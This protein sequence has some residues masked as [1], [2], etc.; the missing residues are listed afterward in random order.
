MEVMELT[1]LTNMHRIA[2]TVL[3]FS[4]VILPLAVSAQ[5]DPMHLR[6]NVVLV[7]L[8]VAVTDD[9]GNYVT[10][11]RPEDFSIT[12]DTR[13]QNPWTIFLKPIRTRNQ[14][15]IPLFSRLCCVP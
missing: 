5:D 11:L 2:Q 9:K 3:C 1:C 8:N 12:E 10:G 14:D 4:C 15:N 13:P 7:Q 6:V